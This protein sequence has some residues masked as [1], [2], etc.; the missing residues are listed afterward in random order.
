MIPRSNILAQLATILV[1]LGLVHAVPPVRR[2]NQA[3][4]IQKPESTINHVTN[5]GTLLTSLEMAGYVTSLPF[6]TSTA[7]SPFPKLKTPLPEAAP[8]VSQKVP[9]ALTTSIHEIAVDP[10]KPVATGAAPSQF[11]TRNQHPVPRLNIQQ[12]SSPLQTNKFYANFYLG[13]QSF[14]SFVHP[15]GLTW[16]KG[17]G[18]MSSWGMAIDHIDY[19][20]K[21]YGPTEKTLP[22]QPVQYIINPVGIQDLVLSAA[23]LGSGT[24]LQTSKLDTFSVNAILSP[25]NVSNT[26]SITFPMV[27]GMG[28]VTAVYK[29]LT[30]WIETGHAILSVTPKPFA[31]KSIFKYS[32]A[33]NNGNTWLV[34]ATPSI[35]QDPKFT[36]SSLGSITGPAGFSGVIQIA[37]I[38]SD[39]SSEALYDASAGVYATSAALT[40]NVA[41]TNGSYTITWTKAGATCKPLTMWALPHHVKSLSNSGIKIYRNITL[42]TTTKGNATA[43]VGDAWTLVETNL[44]TSMGF[45]PWDPDSKMSNTNFPSSVI[46]KISTAAISELSEDISAQSN[47]NSMYYSGKALAKFASIIYV[48]KDILKNDTLV[49]QG[50]TKLEKA[51]SLFSTNQQQ[52]PLVYDN[53]WGGLVS[54]AGYINNALLAD[55]GNTAYNDHHFHYSYFIYTAAVIGYL[56][57]KWLNANKDWVNSLVRDASNPSKL[58]NV[59]PVFRMFDW[60][61]GHSWAHGLFPAGDSKDEESSS[62]DTNFAYALKMWGHVIGDS[63]MEARGNLMLSVLARS[64]QSYFLYEDDNDV[65]P[66]Q[67]IG[68]KVSGILFE[69]KIDHTTYFGSALVSFTVLAAR[70]TNHG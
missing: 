24:T 46:A 34:Y 9:L 58:D 60:Y 70:F 57:P 30:P 15:Y 39:K 22:G 28:F 69:N 35:Q 1:A 13:D 64:L 20:E 40:G 18:P 54:S 31:D 5:T 16:S 55:F 32:V 21:V 25:S 2:F 50:L 36:L 23:E 3:S 63:S 10:F 37:K 4:G 12:Q 42:T 49:T 66:P 43:V 8:Q 38:S 11:T 33:L 27:Q 65:M 26:A 62:E 41:S 48:A 6:V 52:F 7:T 17:G 44:P 59:Y 47:L 14:G 61:H 67:F 29:N 45:A 19:N 53:A 68:N 51:F 56:D